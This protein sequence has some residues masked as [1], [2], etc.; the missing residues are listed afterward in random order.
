MTGF[1]SA[2]RQVIAASTRKNLTGG[3]VDELL[4]IVGATTLERASPG[5]CERLVG[6][7]GAMK[8]RTTW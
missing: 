8:R 4:R 1:S 2:Q 7:I 5:Q 6:M 3:D